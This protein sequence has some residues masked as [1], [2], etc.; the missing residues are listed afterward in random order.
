MPLIIKLKQ[1]LKFDLLDNDFSEKEIY[2]IAKKKLTN[3][4]ITLK[5]IK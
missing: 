5:E 2:E 3:M 4:I 1:N